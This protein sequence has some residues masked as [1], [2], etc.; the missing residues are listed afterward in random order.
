[1]SLN[2]V[3]VRDKKSKNGNDKRVRL[4]PR[5]R[6]RS[7]EPVHDSRLSAPNGRRGRFK[8]A[9]EYLRYEINCVG[10]PVDGVS[11]GGGCLVIS[12]DPG[13]GK[14]ALLGEAAQLGV[15]QGMRV[16]RAMGL[17]PE[18]GLPFAGLH[19]VLRPFLG[20]VHR[21]MPAQ[22][23]ALLG[24][25]GMASVSDPA[26]FRVALAALELLTECAADV[27][28]LVLVEDGHLLDPSSG[29]ALAFVGRR[30][31]SDP[32]VM[33]VA[34][35]TGTASPLDGRYLPVPAESPRPSTAQ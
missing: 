22:R 25:F 17:E 6:H 5:R 23:D 32:I 19:Q 10:G 35:R 9:P 24:A 18:A 2:S 26:Q 21:L 11:G 12:G 16:V 1:M 7:R 3:H 13:V 30:L 28:V 34:H 8:I 15:G 29:D 33:L 14:S 4:G 27:P 20:E 31:E